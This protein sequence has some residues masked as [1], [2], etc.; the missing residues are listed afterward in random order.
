MPKD[1]GQYFLRDELSRALKHYKVAVAEYR[2]RVEVGG[3]P[4]ELV[5]FHASAVAPALEECERL[6]ASSMEEEKRLV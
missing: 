3:R 4:D 5:R 1:T 6:T 2:H